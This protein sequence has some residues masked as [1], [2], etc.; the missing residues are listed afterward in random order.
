VPGGPGDQRARFR[1]LKHSSLRTARAW[2]LKETLLGLWNYT[3]EGAARNFF[4]RWFGWATRSRLEPF[5]KVA[6]MIKRHLK[7]V[8]NYTNHPITNAVA[9]ALNSKIRWINN[10]AGR[11][12]SRAVIWRKRSF[13]AD[14][15]AGCRFV[16]RVMTAVMSRRLPELPVLAFLEAAIKGHRSG[17]PVPSL[18]P[19]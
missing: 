4:R 17:R 14:S 9:E 7:G 2:A 10:H 8:L 11:V 6:H 1:E 12:L 5:R 15:E 18:V 16:E 13:G 19:A 3:Y